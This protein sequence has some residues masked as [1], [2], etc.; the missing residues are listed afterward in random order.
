MEQLRLEQKTEQGHHHDG[1]G[2]Q[3]QAGRGPSALATLEVEDH[4]RGAQQEEAHRGLGGRQA[5]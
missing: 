1:S 2:S 3:G 5:Q 4:H